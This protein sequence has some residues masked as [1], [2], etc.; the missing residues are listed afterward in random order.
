MMTEQSLI[1]IYTT[2]TG[3]SEALARSVVIHLDLWQSWNR[4]W[5]E[6]FDLLIQAEGG[7]RELNRTNDSLRL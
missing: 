7:L 5:K 2:L 1:A 3:G 4:T 6:T